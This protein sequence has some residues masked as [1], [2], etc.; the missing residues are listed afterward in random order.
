M[1]LRDRFLKYLGNSMNFESPNDLLKELGKEAKLH[2]AACCTL[3]L[4]RGF[5]ESGRG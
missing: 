1:D 3:H 2:G 4:F 5:D